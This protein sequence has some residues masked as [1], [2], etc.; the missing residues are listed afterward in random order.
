M[1]SRRA[2]TKGTFFLF[3]RT[4]CKNNHIRVRCFPSNA[5]L[6]HSDSSSDSN[7]TIVKSNVSIVSVRSKVVFIIQNNLHG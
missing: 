5:L 6:K 7:Y 3:R 4:L 2:I 1:T